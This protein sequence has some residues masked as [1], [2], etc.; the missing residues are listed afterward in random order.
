M[1]LGKANEEAKKLKEEMQFILDAVVS[2]G[3][4][5]AQSFQDA[6]DEAVELG[7]VT[8]T[9]GNTLKKGYSKDL[10]DVAKTSE[11]IIKAQA[12]Q[13]KGLLKNSEIEKLQVKLTEAKALK[14]ARINIAK[15]NGIALDDD[16]LHALNKQIE[17]QEEVLAQIEE[18]NKKRGIT[19]SLL[20][21]AKQKLA[22]IRPTDIATAV[23]T[24]MVKMLKEVDQEVV[25]I[26][27]NFAV[28]KGEA[29]DLNQTLARTALEANTLGVN[30]E[31]V[32][33]A[34]NTLNTGLG[35]TAFIFTK[36][37]RN[38]V[39]Y[40]QERLKL[41]AEATLGLS[42][43]AFI[44]GKAISEVREE[45]EGVLKAVK[46]STG[47]SLNFQDTLEEANKIGGAL[48]LNMDALP[49]GIV[50]AVAQAKSLGMEL[51][52]IKGI[53]S[54][55]LDFES[56]IA[57]E[58]EAEALTNKELNL[59]KARTAALN[60]DIVGL[61]QEIASQFGSITEFQNLNYVQ[62]EAFARAAGLSSDQLADILMTSESINA[63]LQTGVE[64]QGES[65]SANAAALS[66][67]EALTQ[68]ISQLNTILKTSLALIM[69]IAAAA[70]V[71]MTGG[72]ALPAV[73]AGLGGA[74]L[75]F[76]VQS[77]LD[78]EAP[79]E[80]GPFTITDSYGATAV[81]AKGDGVVV[82]P[83]ISQGGGEGITKT[84]ANEMISLLKQVAAKDF[85]INMDGRKLSNAMQT[86]G[87][88]YNS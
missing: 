59:E 66:A 70:L 24:Y 88:S 54:S 29:L 14:E 38:D 4:K 41:S 27:R 35:G 83:N 8:E 67:Q 7:D 6:V 11:E 30:L 53:Q 55:I 76:G 23:F 19:G 40:L 77:V 44:T 39:A 65:L 25:E 58:L 1:A 87:V 57:A 22:D 74:G 26:Q 85:S 69:G 28:T 43:T 63:N 51:D 21:K 33:K 36:E 73:L 82:S 3:D 5:L 15:A 31:S 13:T 50:K 48:R 84:Q 12:R 49:G 81:T 2:I 32:T 16:Q 10:R 9:L 79:S 42:K 56:S 52:Q 47:V 72:A 68:S 78:G 62:Q 86:S 60:N 61:T 34:V 45:Q 37:I 46:A 64:T 18:E 20:D 75:G 71:V 80:R 17:L